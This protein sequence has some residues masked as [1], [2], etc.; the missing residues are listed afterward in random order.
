MRFGVRF[1]FLLFFS[2]VS[3]VFLWFLWFFYGFYGFSMISLGCR[4]LLGLGLLG[5]ALE[6]KD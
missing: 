4:S 2:M 6:D 3:M 1:F 5:F